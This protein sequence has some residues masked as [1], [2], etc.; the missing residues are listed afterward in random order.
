MAYQMSEIE[1][2]Y[3]WINIYMIKTVLN[4]LINL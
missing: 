4:Y 2:F 3:M 1:G